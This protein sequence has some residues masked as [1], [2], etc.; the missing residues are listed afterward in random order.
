[1]SVSARAPRSAFT[2]IELLVVIAIIAILIGLLLPAVQKVREAAARTKCQNNLKQIGL[3]IANYESQTGHLPPAGTTAASEGNLP[4][5]MQ[6]WSVF[7]LSNLEQGNAITNYDF[8]KD[9]N[10]G[11]NATIAQTPMVIMACPSTSSPR[12]I[13]QNNLSTLGMAVGDYAPIVRI[14]TELCG[15]N[16]LMKSQTPPLVISDASTSKGGN[17]GALVT[18]QQH[19]MLDVADG[20]SQTI[21]I[22]EMAGGSQLWQL[23]ALANTNANQGAPWADRNQVMAPQGFNPQTKTR[24]G[25]QMINGQNASEVYSFHNGGANVVFVDGHVTFLRQ[26]ISP[27]VFIPL[28]TRANGDV[29]G[30]F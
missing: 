28:A 5:T 15:P 26:D 20:T 13:D 3:A 17:Q 30:D 27:Y 18:N 29:V 6:G 8:T 23:G 7:I 24:L 10:V 14:A 16:G 21:A 22:A 19:K 25:L 2:L 4:K 11:V 12:I 1:M 9:W